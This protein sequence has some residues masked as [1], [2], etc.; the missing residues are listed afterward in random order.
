MSAEAPSGKAEKARYHAQRFGLEVDDFVALRKEVQRV[1][2]LKKG[3]SD[4]KRT[5]AAGQLGI[6]PGELQPLESALFS[7]GSVAESVKASARR[8][9]SYRRIDAGKEKTAKPTSK[10]AAGSKS[11]TDSTGQVG[12]FLWSGKVK[13]LGLD[14]AVYVTEWGDCVHTFHDCHGIQG[15]LRVGEPDRIVV[16]VK[17]SAPQCRGRRFCKI[18]TE[19]SDS[20]RVA[21]DKLLKDFHGSAQYDWPASQPAGTTQADP[22]EPTPTSTLEAM[23]AEA[24]RNGTTINPRPTS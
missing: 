14:S 10:T 20:Y 7:T 9:I 24:R 16:K 11:T 6:S 18:C 2:A 1:R 8:V 5:A 4:E 19:S 21:G 23:R 17:L 13:R 3:T 22:P 12:E 15:Y